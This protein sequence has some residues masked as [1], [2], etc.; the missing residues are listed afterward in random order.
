MKA[1]VLDGSR[2]GDS[3]TPLAVLGMCLALEGCRAVVE[4]VRLREL[5]IAP[6]TG[7]FGCWTRTPG[8]CVFKDASRDIVRS[9]VCSDVVVY[10]TLTCPPF[11]VDW[12]RGFSPKAA[13]T[14][15]PVQTTAIFGVE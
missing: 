10:A 12:A 8:E 2:E 11:R 1:L 6:C 15:N 7:C 9:Y 4:H 5:A 13:R 3:L 14:A